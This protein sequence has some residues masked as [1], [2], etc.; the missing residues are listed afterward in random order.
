MPDVSARVRLD[1]ALREIQGGECIVFGYSGIRNRPVAKAALH[2]FRFVAAAA[3]LV[4]GAVLVATASAAP[5]FASTPAPLT[6]TTS[7]PLTA[8]AGSAFLAKLD[9]TGGTKPYTWSFAGG[10]SL[11]A[12]LELHTAN[13]EITGTPTGPAGTVDF[14]AEVTD[15]EA[16]PATATAAESITVTVT[17]LMVTTVTLPA[18]TAKDM[19]L[20]L[21]RRLSRTKVLRRGWTRAITM[22]HRTR[23]PG[24]PRPQPR[25]DHGRPGAGRSRQC[26]A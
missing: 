4:G 20:V 18:A 25:Y 6:R 11:P 5:A 1:N 21:R 17:P 24:L 13:G 19:H 26:G 2:R 15:S 10:T 7:T 23:P 8:T 9:A 22:S 12:G 3:A 14:I 16:T